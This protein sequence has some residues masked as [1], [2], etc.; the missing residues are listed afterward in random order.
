LIRLFR[1]FFPVRTLVLLAVETLIVWISFVLGT[2]V[3][4]QEDWLLR[5][6]NADSPER[7]FAQQLQRMPEPFDLRGQAARPGATL[8]VETD[9]QGR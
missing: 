2:M 6:S 1:V 5:L 3:R 9:L 8:V 4:G 7:A